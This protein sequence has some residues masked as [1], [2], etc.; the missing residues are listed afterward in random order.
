MGLYLLDETYS[1]ATW[2]E[3]QG[4]YDLNAGADLLLEQTRAIIDSDAYVFQGIAFPKGSDTEIE[5][6]QTF[7][8]S[9]N[10]I[11]YSYIVGLTG[12]SRNSN[13]YTLRIYDKG[14][15]TDVYYGQFAWY[16]TVIG[17]MQLQLNMGDFVLLRDQDKPFGPYLFRS[18]LIVLPPGVLQI[19]ITNA[20]LQPDPLVMQQLQL[21]FMVA[22]PKSTASLNNRKVEH[23]SDPSGLQSLG[24]LANLVGS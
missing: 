6:G 14:A 1:A 21:L 23:S 24:A 7:S 22:V 5:F 19:Q 17:N 4:F 11:P 10:L 3:Y 20:Q 15:Q 13:Q 8:G 9:L 16:P 12:F 2:Y 18:P